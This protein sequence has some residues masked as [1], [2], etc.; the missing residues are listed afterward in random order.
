MLS[1]ISSF[2]KGKLKKLACQKFPAEFDA[3]VVFQTTLMQCGVE[4]KW[5]SRWLSHRG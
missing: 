1:S 2:K 5:R 4:V 3:L